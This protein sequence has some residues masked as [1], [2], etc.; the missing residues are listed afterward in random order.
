MAILP[1]ISFMLESSNN[2]LIIFCKFCW[3]ISICKKELI[4]QIAILFVISGAVCW[5]CFVI[6]DPGTVAISFMDFFPNF[7]IV[8]LKANWTICY[9]LEDSDET[10]SHGD[11]L[12]FSY[13]KENC[14]STFSGL[15]NVSWES[16]RAIFSR[17]MRK[18][19]RAFKR[20]RWA[21]K[22]CP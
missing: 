21:M 4:F 18:N 20:D 17:L 13:K 11:M 2:F 8:L 22:Q 5:D 16:H 14:G 19:P 7:F 15:E 10:L 12:I 6:L 1:K 9:V 3:F